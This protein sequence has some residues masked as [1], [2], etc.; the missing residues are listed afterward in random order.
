MAVHNSTKPETYSSVTNA[1][2]YVPV[3]LDDKDGDT[4]DRTPRFRSQLCECV[5]L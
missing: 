1:V 4:E 5:R 2:M 3:Q